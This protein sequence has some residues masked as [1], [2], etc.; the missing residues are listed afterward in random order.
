MSIMLAA[1][2]FGLTETY[3]RA[4]TPPHH[5]DLKPD[6]PD[7][8]VKTLASSSDLADDQRTAVVEEPAHFPSNDHSH[9]QSDQG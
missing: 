5:R 4:I 9:D 1:Q 2:N 3:E 6:D 8:M 7:L